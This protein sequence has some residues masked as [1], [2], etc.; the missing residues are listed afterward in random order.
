MMR[1]FFVALLLTALCGADAAWAQNTPAP[2]PVPGASKGETALMTGKALAALCNSNDNDNAFAC[3]SYIAGVVDYDRLLRSLGNA[4][5]VAFCLPRG[6]PMASVKLQVTRF[7]LQR[8]E[9]QDFIAA[10]GVVMALANAWPC[11]K[12][13]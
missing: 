2:A 6:L 5:S 7:L 3:Q 10:P 9:H 1:G 4:P 13:R 12:K 11:G 8:T